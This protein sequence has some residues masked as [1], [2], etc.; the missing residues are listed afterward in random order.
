MKGAL[1]VGDRRLMSSLSSKDLDRML[2]LVLTK[3]HLFVSTFFSWSCLFPGDVHGPTDSGPLR[4][5]EVFTQI[6]QQPN[7]PGP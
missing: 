1:P 4:T 7:P 2:T 3:V 6:D 5:N